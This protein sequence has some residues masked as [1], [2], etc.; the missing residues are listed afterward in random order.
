M[1]SEQR[2][3]QQTSPL[4]DE[5][6]LA[7]LN[8][9]PHFFVRH[10]QWLDTLR[11]PHQHKGAISLVELQLERQRARITTLEQELSSLMRIASDNE[12]IFRIYADLYAALYSG[13][14][15]CHSLRDMSA[16]MKQ[17]FVER[18]ELSGLRM[19]LLDEA[20]PIHDD[21]HL[22]IAS[23]EQQAL[24]T[25]RLQQQEFY[26]GRLGQKESQLLFGCDETIQ[27]VALMRLGSLGILAFAS[28]DAAHFAPN[29]DTLLL[30]VLGR[31]LQLRLS[32]L[33][34]HESLC[35]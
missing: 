14:V 15:A 2:Q 17:T 22:F 13:L 18:L 30:A 9:D 16:V 12:R 4:D 31:L 11:L 1:M 29:N 6:V 28:A 33:L 23:A 8:A 3:P 25:A 24:L 34:N 26:L 5:A 27:S 35:D 21:D 19:W 32:T 7:Y 10:S 20:A